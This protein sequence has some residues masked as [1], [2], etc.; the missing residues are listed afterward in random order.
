M[1]KPQSEKKTHKDPG[2]DFN[3]RKRHGQIWREYSEPY[4][5]YKRIPGWLKHGIY[6][7]LFIWGIWYMIVYSGGF[8]SEQ[9]QES[10]A[11]SIA[12]S[13]SSDSETSPSNSQSSPLSVSS[14]AANSVAKADGA[15]IYSTNCAACHQANGKGI[16][17]AFPPLA[18]SDWMGKDDRTLAALVLHGLSGAVIVNGN[19]YNG[20]MPPMGGNLSDQ[21]VSA[22]LTH[23][24]SSFGNNFPPVSIETVTEVRKQQG[25]RAPWTQKELESTYSK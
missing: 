24:R 7:P 11:Y 21:E 8:D 10:Y 4:E 3:V 23:I 13:D 14:S 2:E 9:Y 16:P 17:G 22:V 15:A 6:A 1:S 19:T 12:R 18:E 5:R 20:V 25:T